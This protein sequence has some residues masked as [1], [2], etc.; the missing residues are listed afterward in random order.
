MKRLGMFLGL[1]L[2]GGAARAD[3]QLFL[4][5]SVS[6]TR[7]YGVLVLAPD[8]GCGAMRFLVYADG[9]LLA[10]SPTLAPGEGAVVR[11]GNGFAEGE[12]LLRIETAGCADQ[13]F[14]GRRVVLKK[15]SP[16]HGWR[17]GLA[18]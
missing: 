5:T 7:S 9:A 11:L 4:L 1:A 13:P 17:A 12:H 2:I 10:R 3:E 18:P 6:E 8:K 16:D 14:T 15:T